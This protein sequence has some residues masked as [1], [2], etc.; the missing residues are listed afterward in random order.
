VR[1]EARLCRMGSFIDTLLRITL[2]AM[3]FLVGS[4]LVL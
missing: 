2:A 4:R 3:L 1:D